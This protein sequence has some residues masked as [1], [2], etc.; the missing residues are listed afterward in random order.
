MRDTPP[1]VVDDID[2]LRGHPSTRL[3]ATSQIAD[4]AAV[5][6]NSPSLPVDSYT[7]IRHPLHYASE[8]GNKDVR[9]EIGKW[10]SERYGLKEEIGLERI[11]MT[12]GASF[13]LM[14]VLMHCTSPIT[15][16]TKQAFLISP[17]YFLAAKIF[18]DA[19]FTGKLTAIASTATSIDF[20]ALRR[21]LQHLNESTPDVPLSDGLAP[22]SRG[23]PKRIYKFVLYCV[24]TYSNPTGQTWDLETRRELVKLAR[25]FDILLVSDDV[26]DFLGNEG[27]KCAI[28]EDGKLLPRLVTI[29]RELVEKQDELATGAGYTVSNCS[30]SKLLGPGLRCGWIE[31]TTGVLAEQIGCVG[32][33]ISGGN[34]S[35][36]VSTLIHH[37][38]KTRTIDSIIGTLRQ[39]YTARC[40]AIIAAIREHLPAGTE[41]CGGNGG[42]FM[43]VGLPE[44][45]DARKIARIAEEQEGV[46]VMNGDM[47]ECPGD[48]N[49]MG[50]GDR[51]LRITES[52]CEEDVAVEG[53]RRLGAAVKRWKSESGSGAEGAL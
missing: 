34:P 44:G 36:F 4:A 28:G 46:R 16:Y 41:I 3:L 25:E 43:W 38:V 27:D 19:G 53:V 32:A 52:Y 8:M 50:W 20:A 30:F 42:F 49:R 45:Y 9:G 26:Y 47:T 14:N 5:V 48:R 22:I 11:L 40:A 1:L 35:H 21:H 18:E 29:D 2:L 23:V 13:G 7:E 37:V 31:T 15:G 33:N 24:P 10:T 6:L 51:W 12:S 39:T 17:A